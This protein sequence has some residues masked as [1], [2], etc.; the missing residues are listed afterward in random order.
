MNFCLSSENT[1]IV[2]SYVQNSVYLNK[3][4]DIQKTICS[5][6]DIVW[7]FSQAGKNVDCL[8]GEVP[9][10]VGPLD[11]AHAPPG[12]LDGLPGAPLLQD[13][14]VALQEGQEGT[15]LTYNNN[16]L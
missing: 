10:L 4:L 7:R 6:Q 9:L 12:V 8:G 2:H 1:M 14:E 3:I 13:D 15:T 16:I 11:G 5:Y